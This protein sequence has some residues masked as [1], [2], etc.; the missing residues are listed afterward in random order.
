MTRWLDAHKPGLAADAAAGLDERRDADAHQLAPRPRGIPPLEQL[1]IVGQV[2]CLVQGLDII[3]RIVFGASGRLVRECVGLD[4]V[5]APQ[6]EWVHTQLGRERVD[7]PLERQHRL[8]ST[9]AAVWASRRCVGEH[10][11]ALDPHVRYAVAARRHAQNECG[12]NGR[13]GLQLRAHVGDVV[14]LQPR[15]GAVTSSG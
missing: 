5:L 7:T 12:R 13:G 3:S 9:G 14:Q 4:E 2:E 8:G 1:G 15:Q 10:G 6:L 11:G